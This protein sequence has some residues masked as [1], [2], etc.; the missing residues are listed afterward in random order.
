MEPL[1]SKLS[2]KEESLAKRIYEES[3]IID[4]CVTWGSFDYLESAQ[5][6][7]DG[8]ISTIVLTVAHWPHNFDRAVKRVLKYKDIIS[9]NSDKFMLV[10]EISDINKAK[11]QRKMGVILA[12]QDAVPIEDN[13]DYLNVFY[14]MGVR[15]IQLTYNAQNYIGSGC[16]ELSYG[17]LTYFG[18]KVVKRMNELGIAID[19]SHCSDPTTLDAIKLSNKPVYITH[20]SVRT[21]CNAYGRNKTDDIMKALAEKG[22]VIGICFSPQFIKRNPETLET[23]PSIVEDVLDHIDYV[24][25]LLGID[26]VAFGSDLVETFIERN[27]LP[28]SSSI[29][30]WRPL[31]PDVFGSG[32]VDHYDP[33]V[34]GLESHLK[35]VNLARGLVARGYKEDEIKKVLGENVVRVLGEIWLR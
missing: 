9:Q 20:S 12:F 6:C 2:S 1:K 21:L 14:D 8:G 25:N 30:W 3:I 13:V 5:K 7:F 32:P 16:C 33:R 22:G 34:V 18:H 19:L 24:V 27:T 17:K 28:A 26:H 10:K 15:V 11:E 23:L 4:G 29:R 31:R 35:F